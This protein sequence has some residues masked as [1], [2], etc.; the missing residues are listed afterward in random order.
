MQS[1]PDFQSSSSLPSLPTLPHNQ[2]SPALDDP[3]GQERVS[4]DRDSASPA[5]ATISGQADF[6]VWEEAER[7]WRSAAWV[8]DLEGYHTVA[9][10]AVRRQ[11]P[12]AGLLRR[13]RAGIAELQADSRRR[14]PAAQTGWPSGGCRGSR[15][16][17]LP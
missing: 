1:S 8:A 14:R 13:L 11:E 12:I 6:V 4:Q 16:V 2:H 7:L 10:A 15:L 17:L 5:G 3:R 9:E